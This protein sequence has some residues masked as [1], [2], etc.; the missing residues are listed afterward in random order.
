MI[1]TAY[2]KEYILDG[3]CY[4][5]LPDRDKLCGGSTLVLGRR[6]ECHCF[7]HSGTRF[8]KCTVMC[9]SV[10]SC[11]CQKNKKNKTRVKKE[12]KDISQ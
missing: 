6:F 4:C 3:L 5:T 11:K 12:L 8:D 7:H 10:S 9:F 2:V 1:N